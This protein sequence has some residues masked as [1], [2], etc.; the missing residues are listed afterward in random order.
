[1]QWTQSNMLALASQKCMQCHGLGLRG[2]C[3]EN[4]C[5]CVLRAIFRICYERFVQYAAS[6]RHLSRVSMEIHSGPERRG[7][8][9]HKEEEYMADL[10]LSARRELSEQEYKIFRFR[11]I[12]GGD[13]KLCARKT[14]MDKGTFFNHV[15]S[16]QRKLGRAFA[17]MEPYPLFPLSEYFSTSYRHERTKPSEVKESRVMP[18]RPP[19]VAPPELKPGAPVVEDP[20]RKAA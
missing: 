14:G 10:V 17:E 8:L 6:K 3:F 7:T 1:M 11:F 12:L 5:D 20:V 15:Y 13:W 18:I 9:G 2:V 19:V 16:I 4:P